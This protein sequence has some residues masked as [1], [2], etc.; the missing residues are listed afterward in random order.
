MMRKTI[1]LGLA[2]IGFCVGLQA[3]ITWTPQYPTVDDTIE[4]T[5]NANQGVSTLGGISP[6]YAHTGV[7]THLSNNLADWWYQ[8]SAWTSG[9]DPY[10]EMTNLGGNQHRIRFHIKSFYGIGNNIDV[11]YLAFVFRDSTG[12]FVGKD[13]NN[14]DIFLPI[15]PNS[16]FSARFSQPMEIPTLVGLNDPLTVEVTATNT[17]SLK[18]Y[19]DGVQNGGT[20]TSTTHS[21]TVPTNTYG[22]HYVSFEATS[23]G[24]PV[25]DTIYY[26]VR[27]A[28]NVLDPPSGTGN[29]I[30][31]VNST[32][33]RLTLLAPGKDFI[34][35]IGDFNDWEMDPNYQLNKSTDGERHWIDIAG[36]TPGQEYAFQYYVDKDIRIADPWADKILD[37]WNDGSISSQIYPNL[38]PYPQ[39]WTSEIVSVLQTNQ[40]PYNWTT[41]NFTPPDNRDLVIYEMWI[42]DYVIRHDYATVIDSLDYLWSLGINALELMPIMEFD[43]N[44]SWGYGPAFYFAPDKYYGPKD[45]LKELI[46]AC[47][48]RGMAVILDVALNHTFQQSPMV[49]LYYDK[50]NDKPTAQN[51]WFNEGIPHPFGLGYDFDHASFY[52]QDVVDTVL[53]Y[54]V[55]EYH[56]DGYRMDLTKGFTNRNTLGSI[57]AWS[58]YDS[59][60]IY[61]LK[62]MATEF[63]NRHGNRYFILE[64]FAENSEEQELAAHGC[65]L[66]GNANE[67]YNQ[68][69]MGWTTDDDFEWTVSHK[70]RNFAFHNLV[71]F[72]ESH[73][74]E[75]LMYRNITFGNQ[76]GPYSTQDTTEA[77]LRMEQAAAFFLTVPGPKM[78]WQFGELGFDYSI[79]WNCRTCSKPPRWDYLQ[80]SRR[81]HLYKVYSALIKLKTN[82][83]VFQTNDFWMSTSG[84]SKQ[85]HLTDGNMSVRVLGNFDVVGQDVW[86]GFNHTGWWYDYMTGDSLNVVDVDMDYYLEPGDWRIFIDQ[87]L[88]VPNLY[89]PPPMVGIEEPVATD[90]PVVAYPNPFTAGTMLEYALPARGKVVVEIRNA[91][92]ASVKVLADEE[93]VGGLHQLEWDGTDAHGRAVSDGVYFYTISFGG[94]RV[95]GKLL[96]V[97]R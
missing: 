47:H 77:L 81:C 95:S 36:L 22:K 73:D 58:A 54:W 6:V 70:A 90:F 44:G 96:K 21:I 48:A 13:P 64:H 24:T 50:F 14:Q 3:Q 89:C 82:Y 43:G 46:D 23:G 97:G 71:G 29:G 37:P 18:L 59:D 61:F 4:I 40:Q 32:T 20:V 35:V 49:R 15:Y 85:I 2:L 68:S 10:I 11:R 65:M 31:Y 38:M 92:G 30:T 41:T 27:P 88:P 69:T 25:R 78:I 93:Q 75:R 33:A 42:K 52:T 17:A 94:E 8:P 55:D 87:K 80:D 66:W 74:E 86:T 53:S 5:Y 26:I 7:I 51:P 67:P 84:W 79:D 9:G 34:Y 60:R 45:K 83:S 16:G 1:L 62:R 76:S 91:M 12:T 63:W 39:G 56:I 72:M 57:S 28:S 19:L